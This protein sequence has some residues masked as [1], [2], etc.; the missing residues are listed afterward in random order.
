MCHS[1][2][3]HLAQTVINDPS[4]PL[5]LSNLL[6]FCQKQRRIFCHQLPPSAFLDAGADV[7]PNPNKYL[8]HL[9]HLKTKKQ[10]NKQ[11]TKRHIFC[12][13]LLPSA[14][15]DAGAT[16]DVEPNPNK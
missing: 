4:A 16:A 8:K 15:L 7:T 12:W 5:W 1:S 6:S 3:K 2:V 11:Q 10:Q 14:F 9:E 13:Q